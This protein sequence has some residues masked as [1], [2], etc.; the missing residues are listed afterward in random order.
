MSDEEVQVDVEWQLGVT[1]QTEVPESVW[2]NGPEA[3]RN[4]VMEQ[5]NAAS[6]TKTRVAGGFIVGTVKNELKK[7][8]SEV[9]KAG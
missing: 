6:S 7:A 8:V 9:S 3:V 4:Y 5:C 2:S 1:T